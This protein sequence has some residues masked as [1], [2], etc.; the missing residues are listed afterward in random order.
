MFGNAERLGIEPEGER[1]DLYGNGTKRFLNVTLEQKIKP[2]NL[3]ETFEMT[4]LWLF[5]SWDNVK[6]WDY[7]PIKILAI[8]ASFFLI[9]IMTNIFVAL[10]R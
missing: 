1:Y 7:L 5:G 8:L 9:I 6:N 4:Y 2:P 10:M 3:L